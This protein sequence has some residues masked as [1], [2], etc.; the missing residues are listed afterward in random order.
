MYA[1]NLLTETEK[2]PV[3]AVIRVKYRRKLNKN[4]T[5]NSLCVWF[6]EIS[7]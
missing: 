2:L 5:Q 4:T 3:P 7:I 6:L 1:N